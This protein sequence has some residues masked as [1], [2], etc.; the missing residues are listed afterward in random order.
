MKKRLALI[1]AAFTLSFI[2]MT[3]LA[4][5]SVKR[6]EALIN[7]ID[8]VEQ[9]Y[10][11]ISQ[12]DR[13]ELAIKDVDRLER[14]FM[15]TRDS[16]YIRLLAESQASLLP[17]TEKIRKATEGNPEQH[18]NIIWIRSYVVSRL[19]DLRS[20]LKY[21]DTAR[22]GSIPVYFYKGR[23]ST[24]QCMDYV[25][26]MKRDGFDALEEHNRDKL[27][28][29]QLTS[30]N[31]KYF[32]TGFGTLTLLLFV[33]MIQEFR[34]RFRYQEELKSK[35]IDLKQ[36]HNELEQIA[37][38]ASH[39]LKEPLRKMQIFINRLLLQQKIMDEGS[40][41]L[42]ERI[43]NSAGR[44]QE[45]IED[46]ADLT[47]LVSRQ[48]VAEPTNLDL[49]MKL[50]ITEL[51]TKIKEKNAIILQGKLPVIQGYPA[52][53]Q[54]L[55]KALLDNALK[56]SSESAEPLI[57]VRADKVM[58]EDL[59]EIN[60]NLSGQLF[61]RILI[62]DNG[63][64]FNNKFMH[65]MFLLFQRLHNQQSSYEGKGTGLSISQRVMA[66]HKGYILA[67]GEPNKGATFK[68]YFPAE[69]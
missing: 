30:A 52:Q 35:L 27:L 4:L 7:T 31:F 53:V 66:N 42:L 41:S 23:I 24:S 50:A 21:G 51:D 54:L 64:G 1:F 17:L 60:K 46:L 61:H 56:F 63:I 13:L 58:G 29:Q 48:G 18:K 55:F 36:S 5:V 67:Q 33:L 32:F 49:V 65:K 3:G 16:S 69:E 20:N 14:G 34:K 45:L 15:I 47:S 6:F 22:D 26:K 19:S 11:I 10:K 8:H 12:L 40:R 57:T 62:S 59:A 25:R 37:F 2:I 28:Y 9:N 44:M 39:D 43:D 68:L 38:A